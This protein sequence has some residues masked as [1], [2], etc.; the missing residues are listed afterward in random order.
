MKMLGFLDHCCRG[1]DRDHIEPQRGEPSGITARTGAD[2]EYASGR[3]GQRRAQPRVEPLR[4]K[5]LIRGGELRGVGV[6]VVGGQGISAQS[7]GDLRC[8]ERN[9]ENKQKLLAL[10]GLRAKWATGFDRLLL[11][12]VRPH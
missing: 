8:S 5:G 7:R 6:V 12:R 2:I 1:F 3:G 11:W 9:F 10:I 4:L